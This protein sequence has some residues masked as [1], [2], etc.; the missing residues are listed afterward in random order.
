VLLINAALTILFL[1]DTYAG[2]TEDKM[3]ELF[4]T[5]RAYRKFP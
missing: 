2:S 1:S 4:M 3:G 5:L